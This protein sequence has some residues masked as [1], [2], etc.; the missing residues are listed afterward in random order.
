[1]F[2]CCNFFFLQNAHSQKVDRLSIFS[3]TS[4]NFPPLEIARKTSCAPHGP[5][6]F[7]HSTESPPF[8][9]VSL[10]LGCFIKVLHQI[11]N[12]KNSEVNWCSQEALRGARSQFRKSV[13]M[14]NMIIGVT[15]SR[16]HAHLCGSTSEAPLATT[17][18]SCK[19]Y[20]VKHQKVGFNY[21][22]KCE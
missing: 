4:L 9:L 11:W 5:V 2:K 15:R 20:V 14:W 16:F 6:R 12:N 7:W 8:P 10:I 1:M 19:N 22:V 18:S 3:G 21:A 17:E 13:F